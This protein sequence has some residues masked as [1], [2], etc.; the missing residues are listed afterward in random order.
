V[1]GDRLFL[2]Q[3]IAGDARF[4]AAQAIPDGFTANAVEV[5]PPVAGQKPASFYLRLRDADGAIATVAVP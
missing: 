3:A 2:A 4:D 5:V 1:T